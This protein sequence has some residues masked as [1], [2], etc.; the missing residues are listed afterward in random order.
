[1]S[2]TDHLTPA[3]AVKPSGR[4]RL[5]VG[6]LGRIG[7]GVAAAGLTA[8]AGFAAERLSRD[9]RVAV[10][11]DDTMGD[12]DLVADPDEEIVV[13]T[14]D[15]VELH[16]EV[17]EPDDV[18]DAS[19]QQVSRP[20]VV[21]SHGYCLSLRS[22]VFQRRALTRAGY[23]VVLWD[24]RGHGRSGAGDPE[25]YDIDRLGRDLAA[26]IDDVVPTGDIALVGHSMGGMTMMALALERPDLIERVV[27]VAFIATSP[28]NLGEVT[29]GLGRFV[30]GFVHKYGAQATGLL[31]PRQALV[32]SAV[33][34]GREVVD[35]F[36]DIGSFSSPVPMSVAQLTTDMIFGTRMDVI[37]AFMP[38]FDAHDKREALGRFDGIEALV[39]SGMQDR[40]TPPEH[41][42]EI[43]RSL[44]GA[45][46]V[47]ISD[48]GHV[49]MLEHPD[50]ISAH[51]L[52]LLGRGTRAAATS[53][54]RRRK[55]PVRSLVTDV[56]ARRRAAGALTKRAKKDA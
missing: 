56:G 26:V 20:T 43:V 17:D 1:M 32:D 7:L 53:R 48:A 46:H 30:G 52:D 24:Q 10:A 19:G 55:T 40:L 11:L 16:V 3:A 4:P 31:A 47:L 2:S 34:V 37:S 35:V 54:T 22:W 36:V 23:R 45:E 42:D 6:G 18:T 12:V 25:H 14:E 27:A 33:K 9:R 15:G 5:P 28:G 50:V 51:L 29:Y 21:F 44:P 8:A 41:S 13:T 38:R 39:L 49:I